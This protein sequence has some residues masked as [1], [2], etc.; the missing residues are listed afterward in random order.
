MEFR[1]RMETARASASKAV[2]IAVPLLYPGVFRDGM[3]STAAELL[4]GAGT[5]A[6]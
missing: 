3:P 2:R 1:Q 5:H 4:E 6:E